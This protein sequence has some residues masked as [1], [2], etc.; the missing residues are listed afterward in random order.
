MSGHQILAAVLATLLASGAQ[1]TSSVAVS[2]TNP[3]ATST[4]AFAWLSAGHSFTAMAQDQ[5]GWTSST[6]P[7]WGGWA[8]NTS[9][10]VGA[11]ATTSGGTSALAGLTQS[12]FGFQLATPTG[13]GRAIAS[14][15]LWGDFSLAAHSSVTISWDL[16]ALGL[17][18]SLQGGDKSFTNSMVL[19]I[20]GRLGTDWEGLAPLYN[21]QSIQNPAAFT[22]S[23]NHHQSLTFTNDSDTTLVSEYRGSVQV[24]SQ[25]AIAAAVPEPESYAMALAGLGII[26]FTMARRRRN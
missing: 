24:F 12:G 7:N 19:N 2:I 25:S 26:G 17:S 1:A 22:I 15:D 18:Q 14:L 4:G 16:S 9:Y 21:T 13:G 3:E 23:A 10:G 8:T 6:E 20:S 11:A 5:I